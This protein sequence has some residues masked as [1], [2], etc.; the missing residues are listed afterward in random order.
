MYI[1]T[2]TD[3]TQHAYVLISFKIK[4]LV[5]YCLEFNLRL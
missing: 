3:S 1:I 2:V 4:A 5:F